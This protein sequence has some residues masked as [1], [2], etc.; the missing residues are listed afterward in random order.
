[1]KTFADL[2]HELAP[3]APPSTSARSVSLVSSY[4]PDL[5]PDVSLVVRAL[6]SVPNDGPFDE[7]DRWL[8]VGYAARGASG[9]D[10]EA[11]Q[12]WVDLS[13]RWHLGATPGMAE[14]TWDGLSEPRT[15]W[16]HLKQLVREVDPLLARDLQ[17]R[18]AYLAFDDVDPDEVGAAHLPGWVKELNANFA[19]VRSI[20]GVL[21][22]TSGGSA[23]FRVLP[24]N[25]FRTF[26]NGRRKVATGP[27]GRQSGVGSAWLDHPGA[28]RYDHIGMWEV[29][30]E[31]AGA[32]N[33]FT[34]LPTS[35]SR[36][37]ATRSASGPCSRVLEFIENVISGG[38][39]EVYQ[40]VLDWLAWVIQNPLGKPGVN[41]VLIGSQ[42]T[43]KGTLGNM[44]LDVF[45][46]A[47]S[48]HISQ[49]RHL[50]GNFTGH[51]EGK[52]FL[53]IDEAMF[54]R[55]P[56][57]TGVYKAIT[58][59]ETINIE[60]K[61]QT[62][63]E[64][65]N[66]FAILVAS[67]SLAAAPI[68]PGDRRATVLEVSDVRRQDHAYFQTLWNEWDTGGREAFIAFLLARD[69][70]QFNSRLPLETDAKADMAAATADSVTR[71]WQ[72]VLTSERVPASSF[73]T[74]RQQQDWRAGSVE[75]LN[76]DL[77]SA[78]KAWAR[79]NRVPHPVSDAEVTRGV[80]RL[81]PDR[82]KCRPRVNGTPVWGGKYPELDTC[83]D[84]LR[85]ALAGGR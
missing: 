70:S 37:S 32:L 14:R 42:G 38:D 3:D 24:T 77:V 52:L 53:F 69:L 30:G 36:H 82:Q 83:R 26:E 17:Q 54:G 51:L 84:R 67:N 66:H 63:R 6:A 13:D 73:D 22:M 55:D 40:Y 49:A 75:I 45:G 34:G 78:Y 41:L 8:A 81:C 43:G 60:H 47:Y 5:A 72:D 2:L 65:R 76:R 33:L 11:R 23:P 79:E 46:P 50:L 68:E 57:T 4:E 7:R 85:G 9:D 18:E 31:P 56:Q 71:F 59:E 16:H 21:D 10:P 44:L 20:N 28:R 27:K 15:G 39:L 80:H 58:T 48:T 62:P 35:S 64:V 29:G 61:G 12:A 19:L 74:K 1:M 25:S